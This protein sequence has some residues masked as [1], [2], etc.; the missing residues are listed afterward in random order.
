MKIK[1]LNFLIIFCQL[2]CFSNQNHQLDTVKY[3]NLNNFMG[4][5]YV[6]ASIPTFIEKNIVNA[7]ENYKIIENSIETTYTYQKEKNGDKKVIKSTATIL[8]D[9]NNSLWEMCF[10][11]PLK[12]KYMIIHIADDYSNTVVT[13]PNKKYLWIMSRQPSMSKVTYS[14]IIEKLDSLNFET[15][16][17]KLI[18]QKW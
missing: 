5:W 6:I 7:K 3:I 1:L 16:K 4:D 17:I 12:S 11:G 2:A 15:N 10:W 9:S 8:D 18:P 13:I 14:K